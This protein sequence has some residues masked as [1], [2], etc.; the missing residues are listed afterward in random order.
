VDKELK[1][2]SSKETSVMGLID[3][4]YAYVTPCDDPERQMV[5]SHGRVCDQFV[6]LS[7]TQVVH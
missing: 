1:Y 4:Y 3:V 5:V 7:T 2:V 6:L